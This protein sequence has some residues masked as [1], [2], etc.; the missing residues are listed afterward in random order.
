LQNVDGAELDLTDEEKAEDEAAKEQLPD[1][2]FTLLMARFK[3][4][5]GERITDAREAKHLSGSPVRLVAPDGQTDGREMDRI[6][7]M[8][9]KDY[10]VPQR[11]IEINRGHPIIQNVAQLIGPQTA[12]A[13]TAIEQLFDSALLAEGL[14]PNPAEM[15]PRIQ[16]L[17]E[18]AT[19]Q[20]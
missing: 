5:L 13:E 14:H 6:R 20:G 17:L 15:L 18:L 1:E 4:V 2:Q 10:E 3:D 19:K 9:D 11:V 16:Q 7:R 8:L 12:L